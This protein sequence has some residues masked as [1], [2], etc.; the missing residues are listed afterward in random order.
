MKFF[1]A[2]ISAVG[3]L[4][5][6]NSQ[7]NLQPED[8]AWLDFQ[9]PEGMNPI[10]SPNKDIKFF[11]PMTGDSIAWQEGDTFNPAATTKDGKIVVMFRSEDA[12]RNPVEY[13]VSALFE[14]LS[15]CR[16]GE[17][18][19]TGRTEQQFR[20]GVPDEYAAFAFD[21]F[22]S[23][24]GHVFSAFFLKNFDYVL[25]YFTIGFFQ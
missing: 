19:R 5:A 7:E 8:W 21:A 22:L 24:R 23:G 9:R 4:V 2:L 20:R 25:L 15:E 13:I 10:I 17:F 1:L 16:I 18:D 3:F 14:R 12:S 11:C 6:C